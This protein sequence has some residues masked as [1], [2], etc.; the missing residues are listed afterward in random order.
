MRLL[1][2]PTRDILEILP[3]GAAGTRTA[4]RRPFERFGPQL[5]GVHLKAEALG[6]AEH[7]RKIIV[8][9][10]AMEAEPEA[11]TVGQRHLLLDR[12]ARIDRGRALVLH[13]VA[14]QEVTA[15]GGGL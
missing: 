13:H 12:L 9:A 10:A 11:E 15:V 7:H 1:A 5:V 4:R 3:R 14:R 2:E 6:I 8:L